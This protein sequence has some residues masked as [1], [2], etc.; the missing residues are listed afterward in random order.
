MP[1]CSSM[2]GLSVWQVPLS[3]F[4]WRDRTVPI[5]LKNV[6][7]VSVIILANI[8]AFF[9][10]GYHTLT[11]VFYLVGFLG[12]L[13]ISA[14]VGIKMSTKN[15]LFLVVVATLI[16]LIDEY[17]HTSVGTLAYFDQAVPSPLTVFGWSVFMI[18]LVATA[19]VLMK[20][21]GLEA[22]QSKKRRIL[23]VFVSLI[24]I[25]I[26]TALQGYVNIF[27][28]V[29]ILVYLMLF[30]AS[31]YYTSVHSLKWNLM[32][33]LSSLLFGLSMEYLGSW[34]GLWTF[35]FNE[36]ISLLILFSWPIRTWT[37]NACCFIFG[38]D[39]S[40][41]YE[42]QEVTP[43]S[44][45][46]DTNKSILVVADT[47]FGLNKKEQKC[48]P[49]AF[50]D[51]IDWVLKLEK[52]GK[53][54]LKLGV[55]GAKEEELFLK[56]PEKIILL[57]DMLELWDASKK[58]IDACSR[59]VIQSL[60]SLSC[61]KI[62]PLG[63]HDYDLEELV[64]KYP[65]GNS[66]IEIMKNEYAAL[67]GD[68][69]F[70][71]LHGHQF[72]KL[73][74]F[75]SWRVL[76][77][78]RQAAMVFGLYSWIFVAMF[79]IY[80]ILFLSLGL[81]GATDWIILLLLGAISIPFLVTNYARDLWNSI[82][83][84]RHEPEKSVGRLEKWW[85]ECAKRVSAKNWNVVYGHTHVIE[86]WS[87][88]VGDSSLT[89]FNIP[90]WVRDSK[91]KKKVSLENVF[92]HAFLYID[93]KAAEFIGWDTR[94]KKPFLIPNDVITERRLYGDLKHLDLE[95]N[96]E[97]SLKEIGWPEELIKKWI[98][99]NVSNAIKSALVQKSK[100]TAKI[101]K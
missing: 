13:V 87:K 12:T 52:K 77:Y 58:S 24:P 22:Q 27:N 76:P 36:P 98:K 28:W 51:F 35:R 83:S 25:L 30:A 4:G 99:Y 56:P 74:E 29:I 100:Q 54:E 96:V 1:V 72:D 89:V 66:R 63:N 41:E 73:F 32:L 78:I 2:R 10:G 55:W 95:Y 47:H 81:S 86:Y 46:L 6:V 20:I 14:W 9:L 84:T 80:V 3:I 37:V 94:E 62:Y 26:V 7:I 45:E 33:M 59:S 91:Q 31:F 97:E 16:A 17:A 21:P 19:K 53:E 92:R 64:G 61:Q 71:F 40:G 67:K 42:K 65:L 79:A 39:F 11:P 15:L 88:N 23:P 50:S 60:G 82:K 57:G 18:F 8:V 69:T 85:K 49:G 90:S 5:N 101:N 43:P 68:R 70:V 34:Q 48:D 75:P 44:A 38:V 93:D